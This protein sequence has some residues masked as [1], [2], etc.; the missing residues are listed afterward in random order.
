MR[1][2]SWEGLNFRGKFRGGC[3]ATAINLSKGYCTSRIPR[4]LLS[5]TPDQKVAL[6]IATLA[7]FFIPFMGSSVNIALPTIGQAF[8]L[9]AV[10][11]SWVA[12]S[13]LLAAAMFLLP[14]GRLADI[15]GRK[16]FFTWGIAIYTIASFLSAV[17]T[18][19]LALI[20][21]RGLQGL[22]GAMIFS[23]GIAIL[24][25][26][27]PRAE[28]G[29]VLGISVGAV[30]LGLSFGPSIGGLLTQ[31]FGWRS[32]F[33]VHVPIGLLIVALIVAKLKGEWAD[34][35]GEVFDWVG[36]L[37]YSISL[38]AVVYGLS[39]LPQALG[40]WIALIGAIGLTLFIGWELKAPSPLM[41]IRLFQTS[42]VF[43]FSNLAALLHY[44]ATF[45]VG[46][47]LSLYL[48]YIKGYGP[49]TAGI[50]LI[51]QPVVM[52]IFSPYAGKLSDR[53]EPRIVASA[54]MGLTALGLFLF[55]VIDNQ[56]GVLMVVANLIV[57]GL[58]FA[59]FS[60]PNTN[61][62]MSSVDKKYFGVASG[63]LGTMRL[64][65]QMLS[66]GIATLIFAV[67]IGRVQITPEQYP[68][69]LK[70]TQVAFLVFGLLCLAGILA[71]LARGRLR[72]AA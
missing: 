57:L 36:S 1:F 40:G 26:V 7:A 71:S 56:S 27:F 30:Y 54:G 65:G 31:Q 6:T 70:S 15:H 49:Q 46:F 45:A 25:S 42:T 18:S 52:A 60:S 17:S 37:I 19:G 39:L 14:F 51:A 53:M 5:Q 58:G 20:L 61:A 29:K 41:N 3:H 16:R 43:A 10:S 66:M 62:V 21:F 2:P 69:F 68:L 59:L 12:T 9:D 44:S 11:L 63:T 22:G 47:L 55:T 38:M 50:I 67:Y 4:E 28:R 8:G 23:T 13:F 24:T 32:V 34:A 48:Q 64:T 33:L 35:R 72:A